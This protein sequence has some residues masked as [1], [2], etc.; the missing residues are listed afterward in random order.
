MIL[1]WLTINIVG[2]FEK[3]STSI[4][5]AYVF[6]F[7]SSHDQCHNDKGKAQHCSRGINNLEPKSLVSHDLNTP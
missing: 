1:G 6:F 7:V 3:S 4:R 5:W 2:K